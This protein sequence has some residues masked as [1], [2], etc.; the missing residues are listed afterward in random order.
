MAKK[1]TE[2]DVGTTPSRLKPKE[3][4]ECRE[5][6]L[7]LQQNV[8]SLCERKIKP[9]EAALDHDHVTGHVRSTLHRNCNSVEGRIKH[10]AG[11]S[12]VDPSSFLRNLL[13]YWSNDYTSNPV[14]PNHLSDSEKKI[15]GLRRRIR[16]AKRAST[17][18]KL[19]AMI[20][21]LQEG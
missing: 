15:K 9:E 18:S 3:V 8:C 14:H 12:G 20:K 4:R 21:E 17:K 5:L 16:R 2:P 10:W 11:R 19:A 7:R 6:F 1:R 13:V